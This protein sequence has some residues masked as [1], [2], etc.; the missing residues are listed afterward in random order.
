VTIT[1]IDLG[2]LDEGPYLE[3]LDYMVEAAQGGVGTQYLG[4]RANSTGVQ[5]L[6]T[7]YN[8]TNLRIMCDFLSRG[9][10]IVTGGNNQ[11]GNPVGTGANW[12]VNTV[13][14]GDFQV[15]NLNT[16]VVEQVWRGGTGVLTGVQL[17]MDSEGT[18]IFM[19]TFAILNH[20]ISRSATVNLIGSSD[21]TFTLVEKLVP[22][23]MTSDPNLFHVEQF[24]PPVGYKYWRLSIDDPTNTDNFIQ[25]GTI[26]LG[27]SRIFHNECF[28]DQIQFEL[29]DF[30]DKINTEGFTNVSNSRTQ[31]RFLGLEFRSLFEGRRNFQILRDIFTNRRTVLKCLWIPTPSATDPEITG[32]FAV[33][34]KLKKIPRETHNNKGPKADY[35]SFNIELDESL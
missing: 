4:L 24:L 20:N 18:G 33:F 22:L 17:D 30:A 27:R 12:K 1:I 23:A 35:V 19:D 28:V 14:F 29:Q 2:Y 31:K 25:I 32:K 34:A 11:W 26:L 15:E 7:I 5:F 9:S 8:T 3:S 16:D 6:A 10:P 13:A 21:P